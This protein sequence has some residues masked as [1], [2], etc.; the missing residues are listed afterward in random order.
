MQHIAKSIKILGLFWILSWT[1]RS[2]GDTLSLRISARCI[3]ELRSG[4]TRMTTCIGFCFRFK[5]SVFLQKR[6]LP[7]YQTQEKYSAQ[8]VFCFNARDALCPCDMKNAA[9]GDARMSLLCCSSMHPVNWQLHHALKR[10]CPDVFCV[11][12]SCGRVALMML[13]HANKSRGGRCKRTTSYISHRI[14]HTRHPCAYVYV[15]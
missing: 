14:T 7:P 10:R 12:T 1:A 11:S 8:G 6:A 4:A 2:F 9:H 5:D 15:S 3:R 13:K